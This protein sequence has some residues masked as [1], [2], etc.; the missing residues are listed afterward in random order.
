MSYLRVLLICVILLLSCK[1]KNKEESF[2]IHSA[3]KTIQEFEVVET[4]MGR[5][6]WRLQAKKAS[7][8]GDTTKI[9]DVNLSFYDSK[10]AISSILTSDS[11]YVF[12][13][14]TMLASG[15]VVVR[16]MESGRKLKGETLYWKQEQGRIFSHERVTIFTEDGIIVGDNFESN[17]TLTNIK[18][19]EV[20][21]VGE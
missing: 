20:K 6:L 16:S 14:G 12:S 1:E 4:V 19:R 3:D 21:A 5:M 17:P 7:I 15:S 13:S 10:G 2:K 8:S 18:I 11:G 9:I